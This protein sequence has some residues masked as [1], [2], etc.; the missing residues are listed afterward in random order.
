MEFLKEIGDAVWM[1]VKVALTFVAGIVVFAISLVFQA[2]PI[3]IALAI[4]LWI[5]L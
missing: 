3:V 1:M 5:F 4:V 2:L